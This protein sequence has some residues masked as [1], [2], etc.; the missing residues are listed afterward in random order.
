MGKNKL[1]RKFIN[2]CLNIF[3]EICLVGQMFFCLCLDVGQQISVLYTGDHTVH[4]PKNKHNPNNNN[5]NNNKK[6]K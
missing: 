5:K 2:Q 4:R 3:M 6:T 1:L